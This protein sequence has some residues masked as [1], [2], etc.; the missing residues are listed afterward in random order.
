MDNWITFWE[1]TCLIAF[2]SYI[3]SVLFIIPFGARD[4]LRLFKE[5]GKTRDSRGTRNMK[6]E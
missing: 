3:I 1:Y 4:I 5:L 6:E 2:G